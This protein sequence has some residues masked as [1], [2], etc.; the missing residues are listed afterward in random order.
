[1]SLLR[2]INLHFRMVGEFL[3]RF[4]TRKVSELVL[5]IPDVYGIMITFLFYIEI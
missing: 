5:R 2:T 1:M 4:L 3:T